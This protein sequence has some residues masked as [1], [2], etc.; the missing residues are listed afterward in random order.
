MK[1]VAQVKANQ[2]YRHKQCLFLTCNQEFAGSNLD[3]YT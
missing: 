2:T 3:V 1:I